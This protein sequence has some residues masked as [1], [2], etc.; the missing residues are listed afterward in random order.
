MD[1]QHLL[2]AEVFSYSFA[3][4][5]DHLGI[6]NVRFDEWMPRDAATLER[7]QREGWKDTRIARAL[8]VTV[9]EGDVHLLRRRLER[10]QAIVDAPDAAMA[11]RNG[12]RFSIEDAVENG[13]GSPESIERLVTQICYRAADLAFLLD[14]EGAELSYY[15]EALRVDS[16]PSLD[17]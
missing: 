16:D 5:D 3:N 12:V 13:L 11:F 6:G 4:Y 7:A 17:G 2:A 9:E 8:E 15:S 14:A 1:R 10:A